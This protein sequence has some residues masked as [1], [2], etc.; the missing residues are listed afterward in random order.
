M[1]S[2][3][4]LDFFISLPQTKSKKIDFTFMEHFVRE[5]EESRLREL[6]AYLLATGLNDYLLTSNDHAILSQFVKLRWQEFRME[7][8]FERAETTK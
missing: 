2:S 4:S 5:L 1:R 7:D 6:E 8:L 3:Q